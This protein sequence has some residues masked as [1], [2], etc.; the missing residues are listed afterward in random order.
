[1]F[2]IFFNIFFVFF[3]EFIIRKVFPGIRRGLSSIRKKKKKE[4]SEI[5]LFFWQIQYKI[6]RH[7]NHA[8]PVI[9]V[10]FVLLSAFGR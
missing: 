5:S 1:M 10:P 7:F 8:K 3:K 4:K 9:L 6:T 2:L